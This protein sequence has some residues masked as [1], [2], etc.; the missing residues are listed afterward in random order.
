M[1]KMAAM[2]IHPMFQ[3]LLLFN[4]MANDF[5]GLVCSIVDMGPTKFVHWWSN[6]KTGQTLRPDQIWLLIHLNRSYIIFSISSSDPVH[7]DW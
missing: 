6:V 1:T 5:L 4:Q 2:V 7:T 3:K